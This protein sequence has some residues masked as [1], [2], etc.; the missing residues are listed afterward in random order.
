[1]RLR[2]AF[3]LIVLTS[4]S[5]CAT[6][7]RAGVPLVEAGA[8][9][10]VTDHG[11]WQPR[12][13]EEEI[14]GPWRVAHGGFE[15]ASE[16]VEAGA[17][18]IAPPP[19]AEPSVVHEPRAP[20]GPNLA[21]P[22]R[23]AREEARPVGQKARKSRERLARDHFTDYPTRVVAQ[24]IT[25]HAPPDLAGQAHLTGARVEDLP[26][27]RRQALGGARLVLGELTLEGDRVTLRTRTDGLD[28]LQV[29]ARGAVQFVAEVRGNI[30]REQ[31][32]KSLLITN[33]QVVPLR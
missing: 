17:L 2:V 20:A 28:D 22:V 14:G 18:E 25:L 6:Q 3:G 26:G 27:G 31:G 8:I 30:L 1:M 9:T 23:R 21:I 19:V 4:L 5:A 10:L 13:A 11:P 33:D 12:A 16:P 15:R 29:M 32:L 7:R 24:R